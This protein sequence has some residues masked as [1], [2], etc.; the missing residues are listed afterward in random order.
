MET[1]GVLLDKLMEWICT[2]IKTS[3][4]SLHLN[5]VFCLCVCVFFFVPNLSWTPQSS[6]KRSGYLCRYMTGAT[7]TGLWFSNLTIAPKPPA[8]T[9]A[10]VRRRRRKSDDFLRFTASPTDVHTLAATSSGP[11]AHFSWGKKN[12]IA[13]IRSRF[14][15]LS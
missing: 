9:V 1:L 14:L 6:H 7:G 5:S 10:L 13:G 8:L 3:E 15:N 4:H 2:N 11:L 12:K